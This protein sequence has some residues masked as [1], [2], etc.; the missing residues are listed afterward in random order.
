MRNRSGLSGALIQ[1]AIDSLS[2]WRALATINCSQNQS[3]SLEDTN[4]KSI[5]LIVQL[6]T[7]PVMVQVAVIIPYS[8]THTAPEQLARATRSASQQSVST[9][10]YVVHDLEQQG[11]AWARNKGLDEA[12]ERYIAFLDADDVWK[13]NKLQRQLDRL[14]ET[15]AGLCVEGPPISQRAFVRGVLSNEILSLTSSIIIDSDQVAVRFDEGLDRR[16][17]HLF[18]LGAT[19]QGG[20]CFVPD[21][22]EINKH[23]RGL[24]NETTFEMHIRSGHELA[25]KIEA[26]LPEFAE[27]LPS[28]RQGLRFAV[29]RH[30]FIDGYYLR[31]CRGFLSAAAIDPRS[32]K[33]TKALAA[34]L[35]SL[36]EPILRQV[37]LSVWSPE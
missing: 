31:A 37:G 3:T 12:T 18:M 21:L 19:S 24:T 15:D 6:M 16:E 26:Q 27:Y 5:E 23:G 25:E 11:P 4:G 1:I 9:E 10:L 8:P 35:L 17:D 22:V 7:N 34:S 13:P 20:V 30:E 28:L 29:A 32:P 33:A 2:R 14:G 36:V